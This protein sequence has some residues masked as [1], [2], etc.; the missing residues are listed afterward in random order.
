[1]MGPRQE[2]QAAQLFWKNAPKMRSTLFI[3]GA[4]SY[5]APIVQRQIWSGDSTGQGLMRRMNS[6]RARAHGTEAGQLR[7]FNVELYDRQFFALHFVGS[8]L[9]KATS[10][11]AGFMR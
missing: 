2:A 6:A 4:G 1:M 5:D 8:Q 3:E 11:H 9:L 7:C 10:Y